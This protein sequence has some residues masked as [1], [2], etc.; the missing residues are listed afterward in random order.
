MKFDPICRSGEPNCWQM[1]QK[2]QSSTLTS[3]Q[4]V[5]PTE[6]RLFCQS[7]LYIHT[8]VSVPQMGTNNMADDVLSN[9]SEYVLIALFS[10]ENWVIDLGKG[11]VVYSTIL[12]GLFTRKRNL[13]ELISF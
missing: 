2:L 10:F 11:P 13:G 5:W 7:I 3:F 1:F 8:D 4:N 12:L 6:F 9:C